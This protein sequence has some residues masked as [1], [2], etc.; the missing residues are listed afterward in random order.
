MDNVFEM[1]NSDGDITPQMDTGSTK[2]KQM[3]DDYSRKRK[4]FRHENELVN[5]I[6]DTIYHLHLF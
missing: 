2:S 1:L 5:H 4:L 6:H 3:D